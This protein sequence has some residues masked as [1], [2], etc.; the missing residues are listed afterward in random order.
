MCVRMT[1]GGHCL[2]FRRIGD[3]LSI[4]ANKRLGATK[5]RILQTSTDTVSGSYNWSRLRYGEI[6]HRTS[7]S[8][9]TNAS[10]DQD[11]VPTP[12]VGVG[13]R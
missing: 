7:A 12:K 2:I 5:Y 4:S 1:I 3:A 8:G 13:V 6:L 11:V 9:Q 10:T